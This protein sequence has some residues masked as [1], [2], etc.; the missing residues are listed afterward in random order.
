MESGQFIADN[1]DRL[2]RVLSVQLEVSR[3]QIERLIKEGYVRVDGKVIRKPS[4]KVQPK[5]RLS[6]VFQEAKKESFEDIDITIEKLYEDDDVLVVNKPAGLVVHPAPSVKEA[7]LV[8]WLRKENIRLSTISG[9]ERNGIVHR[10]DKDTSGAILIAKNNFAHSAL[11]GQLQNRS[12]GR[13]YLALIDYPLKENLIVQKP[14]A[15]NPKN[16]LKMA[17]VAG[18]RESKTAFAKVA[19]SSSQKSE[20]IAC[21]LFSGRTHQIRVH[22]GALSR[23]ILGDKLYGSGKQKGIERTFLHA[24]LLYFIHPRNGKPVEVKAPLFD[25]MREYIQDKFEKGREYESLGN[26]SIKDLFQNFAT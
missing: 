16:R 19:L 24:Y 20:L 1:S 12:M 11:S 6:Y 21:K 18:G 25:D 15:R 7:T 14:I 8:D 10:L 26:E 5:M 3:N 4:F 22:L 2:D 9:E 17:I 13:Y 23:H